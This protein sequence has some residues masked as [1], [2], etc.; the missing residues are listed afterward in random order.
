MRWRASI[1]CEN[2][3][4][5]GA[6]STLS[7]ASTADGASPTRGLLPLLSETLLSDPQWRPHRTPLREILCRPQRRERIDRAGKSGLLD[8]LDGWQKAHAGKI[9]IIQLRK[10]GALHTI[11]PAVDR[12]AK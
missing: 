6:P 7:L 10:S 8:H 5:S 1:A 11:E 2:S 12:K 4:H 9:V 3:E